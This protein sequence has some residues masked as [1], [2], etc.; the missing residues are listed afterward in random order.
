MISAAE[1]TRRHNKDGARRLARFNAKVENALA[2]MRRGA[3]LH[4]C[5]TE[6]GPV[7]QLSSGEV[8]PNRIAQA[9]TDH[10]DVV[11]VGYALFDD[12]PGQTWRYAAANIEDTF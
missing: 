6:I 4:L 9:V 8:L 3:A 7:W 2:D 12:G 1:R 5:F 10:R 11:G